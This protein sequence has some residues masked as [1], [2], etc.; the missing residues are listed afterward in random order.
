MRRVMFDSTTST[1]PE[2]LASGLGP[3]ASTITL[4]VSPSSE[5]GPTALPDL[6]GDAPSSFSLPEIYQ[7]TIR[8]FQRSSQTSVV[9]YSS[10]TVKDNLV[11]QESSSG[12][13]LVPCSDNDQFVTIDTLDG[14]SETLGLS[15][16]QLSLQSSPDSASSPPS[17][18]RS[19]R[20]SLIT[21]I[22]T[23]PDTS[24]AL[25]SGQASLLSSLFSLARSDSQSPK[26]TETNPNNQ[27]VGSQDGPSWPSVLWHEDE[28]SVAN[29]DNDDPEG[30]RAIICRSPTPDPNTRSNA[31]PFVLQAS[32]Q[33]AHWVSFI[34]FE[35]LKVAG[36]IREGVVMQFASSP[37]VRTRI[38]LIAN[39][40][41]RL[42]NVPELGHREMSIVGMLRTQAHQQIEDFHSEGPAIERARDMQN[43]HRVLDSMMEMVLIQRYSS[44]L[45]N[46]VTL[47]GAA[48]SVFR[49]A[50][51]EPSD[52][53]VNL[54][55]ILTSPGLNLQHFAATDVLISVATARPMFFKYDVKCTPQTYAQLL[56]GDYG[57]RW[58]HGAPDHFIVL[59]AW[60]NAL[61]EEYG[62]NVDPM[63]I[64]EIES[65]VRSTKIEPNFT[66][67]AVLLILRLAVQECW[68]QAVCVYLYMVLCGAQADDPR[69]TRAVRSFVYIVD[70]VSPGRNPDSFLFIPIMMVGCFAHRE[71]DRSVLRRRMMGLQE[72]S[73]PGA[74]S[75]ECLEV[76]EDV[77]ERTRA[78]DRPAVWSDLRLSYRKITGV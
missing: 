57:L 72:C 5:S 66:P 10:A 70:G 38:C 1:G 75:Y 16:G 59:L 23:G 30:I 52:Q 8:D 55:N 45:S 62:T 29:D 4:A 64:G 51:P 76:L 41:G 22:S 6:S 78:E 74:A 48:A 18:S 53:L 17:S 35:P 42:S 24:I 32:S 50:C 25:T 7:V 33:D 60:I 19:L 36:M 2:E 12:S 68:R 26:L 21:S 13:Q 61:Y 69:V 40:I 65:Q 67:D 49:R 77:W 27:V 37:G 20:N 31:L 46:I 3:S 71:Q 11:S 47:M 34:A 56:K 58:L 39:V 73:N 63:Y 44:P 28:D 43:A 14:H 9:E 54:P 15:Q